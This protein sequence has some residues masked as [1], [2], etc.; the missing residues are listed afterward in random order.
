MK[1]LDVEAVRRQARELRDAVP[2]LESQDELLTGIVD[3][4]ELVEPEQQRCRLLAGGEQDPALDVVGATEV[5]SFEERE[6][7]VLA[8]LPPLLD[9][10]GVDG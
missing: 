7:P 1:E 5:M 9:R 8:R 10:S 6:L 2:L 3:C 4:V